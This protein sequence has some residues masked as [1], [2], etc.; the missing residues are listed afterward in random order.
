MTAAPSVKGRDTKQRVAENK[1]LS[2][3]RHA[4]RLIGM[5]RDGSGL[6][7]IDPERLFSDQ[8]LMSTVC[9]SPG[10]TAPES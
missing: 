3:L 2:T 9:I 8:W 7:G 6:I 10:E 5:D 1:L 4:H